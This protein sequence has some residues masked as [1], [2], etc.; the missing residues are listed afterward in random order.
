MANILIAVD[1]TMP[2]RNV[3]DHAIKIAKATGAGLIVLGIVSIH[4]YNRWESELRDIEKATE[5]SL[6]LVREMAE[7][8]GLKVIS[9]TRSGYPD[10]EIIKASREL[11]V[12]MVVMPSGKGDGS[13]IC[14]AS[15]ILLNEF[16]MLKKPLTLVPV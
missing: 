9:L 6:N 4:L 13:E 7:E 1:H 14:K 2:S 8:R 15:I 3:V 11:D 10:E 16:A 12:S 5:R